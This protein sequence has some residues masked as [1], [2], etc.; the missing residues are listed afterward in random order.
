MK[1]CS[2]VSF[3][4]KGKEYFAIV[5]QRLSNGKGFYHI[6]IMNHKLDSLLNKNNL[7]LIEVSDG[8]LVAPTSGIDESI[9]NSASEKTEKFGVNELRQKAFEIIKNYDHLTPY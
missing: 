8:K 9:Q 3:V 7:S 1:R 2:S 6:R 4:F 5:R